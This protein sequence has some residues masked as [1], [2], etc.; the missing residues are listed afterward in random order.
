MKRFPLLLLVSLGVLLPAEIL[1]YREVEGAAVTTHVLSLRPQGT[2][3]HVE[4]ASTRESGT[5]RQT[6]ST[7]AD[8]TTLAWTFSDPARRMELAAAVQGEAIVLAGSFQGKKVA[9]KFSATGAPWNQLFQMGLG[10]FV[11]SGKK[12]MAFRSIGT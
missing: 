10:P 2:G 3:F 7:A 1:T 9:K 4:L 11:L 5:V 6:F 8:L 12:S